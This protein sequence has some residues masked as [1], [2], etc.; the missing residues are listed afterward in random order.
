VVTG[1]VHVWSLRYP[2][3]GS[4]GVEFARGLMDPTPVL[5]VHAA[6]EAL[7]VEVY[8]NG[9]ELIATGQDLIRK[10]DPTPITRLR[11]D[12]ERITREDVWPGDDDIGLPVILPGG[13]VGIITEWS[14][15]ADLRSWEWSV[16]FSNHI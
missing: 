8:E 6:P 4:T 11:I 12:G 10:S 9:S 3:A 16:R 13:E 15:A 1:I 14:N 2:F 5:L 7:T